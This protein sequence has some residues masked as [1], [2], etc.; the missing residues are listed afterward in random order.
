[1]RL[2]TFFLLSLVPSVA[3]AQQPVG[4]GNWFPEYVS[5]FQEGD[6][7]SDEDRQY[8]EHYARVVE[9]ALEWPRPG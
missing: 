6:S 4:P 2:S 8:G 1:M 7:A 9:R 3:L 5:P